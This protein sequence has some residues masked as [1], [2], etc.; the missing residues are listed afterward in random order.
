MDFFVIVVGSCFIS[1]L[2]NLYYVLRH[3]TYLKSLFYNLCNV[4]PLMPPVPRVGLPWGQLQGL[5]TAWRELVLQFTFI[6][7]TMMITT[8]DI[9]VFSIVLIP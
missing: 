6:L 1:H 4:S 2:Q 8:S 3:A 7:L 5:I 9:C